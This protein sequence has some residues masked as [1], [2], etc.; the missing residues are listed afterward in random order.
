MAFTDPIVGFEPQL[1]LPEDSGT[2]IVEKKQRLAITPLHHP[3]RTISFSL[4]PKVP[5][6][7][8]SYKLSPGGSPR[9]PV[10]P[11]CTLSSSLSSARD[12]ALMNK[13]V[14][15][16]YFLNVSPLNN[17]IKDLLGTDGDQ[18]CH[19]EWSLL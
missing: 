4:Q 11:S 6:A 15:G 12:P 17:R 5:K 9:P 8:G 14:V 13:K 3:A 16:K 7:T 18:A 2:V 1:L 10:Q 19:S